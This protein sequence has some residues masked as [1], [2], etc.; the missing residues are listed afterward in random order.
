MCNVS[1]YTVGI[2]TV[3]EHDSHFLRAVREMIRY[4]PHLNACLGGKSYQR[5][6]R[7]GERRIVYEE[8]VGFLEAA[9]REGA[10]RGIGAES[11]A[12]LLNCIVKDSLPE[13][14]QLDVVARPVEADSVPVQS[15][16]DE[17]L[18][19]AVSASELVVTIEKIVADGRVDFHEAQQLETTARKVT[20]NTHRLLSAAHAE[21]R[22]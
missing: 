18:G 20:R 1:G 3:A 21:G 13:G 19:F 8:V 11:V 16:R 10:K 14:A 15:R 9:R 2:A 5:K 17:Q 7:D 22:R 4:R 12:V 6:K